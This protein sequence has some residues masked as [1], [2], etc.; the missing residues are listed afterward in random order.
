[1]NDAGNGLTTC[2]LRL[3][4]AG[5]GLRACLIQLNGTGI[6]PMACPVR[7]KVAGIRLVRR[8]YTTT[9]SRYLLLAHSFITMPAATVTGSELF[10][11]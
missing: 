10:T 4:G 7:P 8:L 1:L 6:P 5:V 9:P 2:L 11:P 3:N